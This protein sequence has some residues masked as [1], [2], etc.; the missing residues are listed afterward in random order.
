MV[1]RQLTTAARFNLRKLYNISKRFRDLVICPV[2]SRADR[3]LGI[4]STVTGENNQNSQ[5]SQNQIKTG[6]S[7]RTV[8]RLHQVRYIDRFDRRDSLWFL[9]FSLFSFSETRHLAPAGRPD[10]GLAQAQR[11]SWEINEI[12]SGLTVFT[13]PLHLQWEKKKGMW[14]PL[15]HYSVSVQIPIPSWSPLKSPSECRRI[16][17]RSVKY[18][19]HALIDI[20]INIL[21]I[22]ILYSVRKTDPS[23]G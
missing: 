1:Q 2:D 5:N 16:P 15:V 18:M 19:N 6:K 9:S 10:T 22:S 8:P 7:S 4:I 23:H 12:T 14:T 3:H 11:F 20:L 17:P 13:A 21:A